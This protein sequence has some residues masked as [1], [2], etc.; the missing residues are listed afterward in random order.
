[1]VENPQM[2]FPHDNRPNDD[3]PTST[4]YD[5]SMPLLER[6]ALQLAEQGWPVLLV[7]QE[8]TK[9]PEPAIPEGQRNGT[10][11]SLAGGL[12][13]LGLEKEIIEVTLQAFNARCCQPPLSHCDVSQIAESAERWEAGQLPTSGDKPEII[14]LDELHTMEL[15]EPRWAVPGFLPEGVSLLAGKPKMGKSW[16]AL[17]LGLAIAEGSQALGS[18]SVERGSVLYMGLEDSHRRMVDRTRKLLQG[19]PAP[20]NFKSTTRWTQLGEAG[21]ADLEEWLKTYPDARLVVIDTLA[22]VRPVITG[23]VY[24]GDY[25]FIAP[26]K[27]LSERYHIAILLVH[28]LRKMGSSD[29]MDEISGTTGL[30]GATDCNMVLQRERGQ[31]FATLTISGRDVEEQ[32]LDLK[33]DTGSALWTITQPPRSTSLSK[34]RQEVVDL[35]SREGRPLSPTEVASLL[36]RDYYSLAKFLSRL[37]QEKVLY[38]VRKGQYA[39]FGQT[40][41]DEAAVEG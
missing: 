12:R 31:D 36:N 25:K 17:H 22:R 24:S 35:F 18:L 26:L 41:C 11:T 9:K 33:F 37:V 14:G 29:P 27:D 7:S 30:I 19:R 34:D 39:L 16:L 21:L 28:H 2:L 4:D 38:R 15:P 40:D 1:M 20:S 10:L 13:R 32:T 23:N 3:K 8:S 6:A 5:R